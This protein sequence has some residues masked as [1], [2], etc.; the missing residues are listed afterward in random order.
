MTE[1]QKM[2]N[3]DN[4]NSRDPELLNQYHTARAL[5]KRYNNLDSRDLEERESILQSLFE[6]C[7]DGVWIEI[8]FI[9]DYG[10]HITVGDNTFINANCIFIDNNKITIGENCLIGPHVQI[11]TAE[12]PLK[13]SE[14]IAK[15]EL[16]TSYLTSTKPV[17]IG[18][19]VWIGGNS[20]IFPGVTIGNNVT[21]GAGSVVTKSIPDNVLAY[22]NP[23]KIQRG[24]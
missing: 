14:R 6:A 21:I 19:N 2:L 22:G 16:G 12:H 7:G 24:L 4:Y 8:P 1:K 18:D 3:G 13:A 9:C 11:Y 5:L 15:K 17:V 20:V 23:C 10:E